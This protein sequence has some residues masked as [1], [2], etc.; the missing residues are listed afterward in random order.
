M[1][2]AL[3]TSADTG[4]LVLGLV[5]SRDRA[6][7]LDAL[8][9]SLC[10]HCSDL[11]LL[12][13]RILYRAT[14]SRFKRRYALVEQRWRDVLPVTF[15]AETDF[16][17]DV[18]ALLGLPDRC[19]RLAGTLPGKVLSR[20]L[21]PR[22]GWPC[23]E[24]PWENLL[25]LVD[26]NLFVAPFSLAGIVEALRR[27]PAAA[28]FS[29]RLGRNVTQCS[30]RDRSQQP[31]AFSAVGDGV[32][33]YEWT[34]AQGSFDYPLEVSSSVYP[35]RTIAGPLATLGYSNP[36]T[37]EAVLAVA[38][39][40]CGLAAHTP[41]LLCFDRSVAF[42]DAV[43][44]VQTVCPDNRAGD[45]A[46]FSAAAL[47]DAFDAGLRIDTQA[48]SGYL[49]DDTHSVVPLTLVPRAEGSAGAPS[50][51][52]SL[53]SRVLPEDPAK[54]PRVSIVIAC[55]NY[56][57]YLAEA[58]ESALA[59]TRGLPEV[60]V[61]D[62]GST[63][64]TAEVAASYGDRLIY[65]HQPD[66]GPSAARNA[67]IELSSGD[68]ITFLDADD[69]LAPTFVSECLE[70][71]DARPDVAFAF[72][73]LEKF[74]RTQGVTRFP[75]YESAPP[76]RRRIP[77]CAF[78]RRETL[79]TLRFDEAL[80]SGLEDLDLYLTIAERGGTGVLVDRPLVRYRQHE[81]HRS[82]TDRLMRAPVL[83][84]WLH[85][86]LMWRHRSLFS[87]RD[88]ATFSYELFRDWAYPLKTRVR[89]GRGAR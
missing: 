69:A 45:A 14:S 61:V 8:L 15:H 6:M 9:D 70:A 54:D 40:R 67:G 23:V 57:R 64:D 77:V 41:Q 76:L 13:M 18:L 32:L 5:F 60:I 81:Q 4:P 49:P 29:L 73:Q 42:C 39:R 78:F 87:L 48:L 75:P 85:S 84:W 52:R 43:N 38:A 68:Y 16:R 55:H 86:R 28:G 24:A 82:I 21:G 62:D 63:D 50:A 31:P 59:Q 30:V 89:L 34:E 3:T 37:L 72:T 19:D 2:E 10:R 27:S 33:A 58:V 56:G 66:R 26:D 22:R 51:D 80:R 74:G 12:D 83:R 36:N 1:S 17:N 35:A 79:A 44:M 46:E 11:S 88:W 25:F 53:R 65:R 71:L 47:A 7:Q 20:V